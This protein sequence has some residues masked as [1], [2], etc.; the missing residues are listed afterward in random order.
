MSLKNDTFGFTRYWLSTA[1]KALP[2]Q[3]EIFARRNLSAARKAFL[4]GDNQLKAIKNWLT[5]AGVI[6]ADGRSIT[7]TELGRLMAAQDGRAETAWTW[8]LFHLHLCVNPDAFPYA[9]FFLLYDSE[10]RWMSLDDVVDC[11]TEFAEKEQIGVTK[12]TVNTYFSGVVQTFHPGRFVHELA[13][14]EER[15]PEEGRGRKRFRRR[16]VSAEDIVV[17]YAAT[18]FQ[19]HFFQDQATVEARELLGKGL[20]RVLGMRDSNL[21]EALS[22]ISTH[23][24]LS[25]YVQYRQQVNQDSIQFPRAGEPA[26]R[27]LRINAYRTQVVKW[28]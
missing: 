12:E 2:S 5:C 18:L 13:L 4:A 3:P 7:L 17:A 16:L 10:G 25:Q 15:T 24:D 9:D 20:A 14:I 28:Q 11:L 19:K 23:K 21:R 27:D 26:L 8:W 1:L 22:R 6:E